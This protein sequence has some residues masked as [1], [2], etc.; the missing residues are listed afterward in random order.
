MQQVLDGIVGKICMVYLDDVLICSKSEQHAAHVHH[1]PDKIGEADVTLKLKGHF[2]LTQIDLLGYTVNLGQASLRR[3][4]CTAG[5]QGRGHPFIGCT[6]D[7]ERGK[8]FPGNAWLLPPAHH[9]L[10]THHYAIDCINPQTCTFQV[11]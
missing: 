3:W 8:I 10:C 2:G 5:G 11:G 7:S 4:H 9:W 6:A 1:V